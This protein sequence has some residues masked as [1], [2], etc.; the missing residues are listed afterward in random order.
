M[1]EITEK[2]SGRR[3]LCREGSNLM[4]AL[5]HAGMHVDN[6]CNGKGTCGKCRVRISGCSLP[7]A[8]ETERRLL[9]E[10]E[11]EDG[12]RLACLLS[13]DRDMTVELLRKEGIHRV[14]ESGFM[15]DFAYEP[16][17]RKQFSPGR[18][19]TSVYYEDTL[20]SREEGDTTDLM[21][22]A[23]LDIGTTT[24]VLSLTDLLSG[25]EVA[26]AA[27]I[28]AQKLYGL[29]VLT[30]IT[31]EIEHP[32]D[33]ARNLQRVIVCS[34]NEMLEE[35]CAKA[36]IS[37]RSVYEIAVAA[38]T[39]M[40][41][42]LL[43]VDAKSIGQAP[44]LPSF[45]SS[46][47]LLAAS[48]GLEAAEQARLYCLPSVSAYIGADIV[49]G[50]YVCGLRQ[51]KENLLFIDIGTNGEIVLSKEGSLS[52]CSCAAGP[53]LEGMNISAG[54]RAADGAIEDVEITEGGVRLSVIGDKPPSGLCGSGI[55][56]A[57]RE[58]VDKGLVKASGVF[59]RR[60][61]LAEGDPRKTLLGQDGKKR[62]FILSES[63]ALR[64]TQSDV[65]QVQLAKGAILSGFYT[66]L[67]SQGM[68]M[69]DLDGV[70]VA[71]QFGA[72]LPAKSLV[73][74]GIL[75]REVESR[76]S[77]VGNA[78]KAGAYMAL[79]SRRVKEELE[80]LSSSIEYVE[81][82]QREGYERL[83]TDCMRFDTERKG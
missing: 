9:G 24:V 32:E 20:L 29:D 49:A 19:M 57:V 10:A 28:N 22:G 79:M 61:S 18:G 77:Y 75:P 81:L 23:A 66:L 73:G 60:E 51:R 16:S 44:F 69:G 59:L 41:H 67:H 14:L 33:G 34:I 48:I 39:T 62:Y 56:A 76:I 31:Y 35:V 55:L 47:V 4:E 42:M 70:L 15:P 12:V 1:I 2:G 83:F 6:A 43:G 21:Y 54:M 27:R 65:R 45:T 64:V 25:R 3:I 11:L 52:S 58:L 82:S 71:G 30:R 7:P 50:A 26:S 40:L 13:A 36:G 46:K 63:P 80:T 68:E 38:N 37:R 53:A 74:A 8:A 78:A 5:L 17:V 72:H